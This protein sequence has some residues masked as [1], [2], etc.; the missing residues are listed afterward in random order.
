LGVRV[1]TSVFHSKFD[2]SK[3]L[4]QKRSLSRC[5]K[6]R[7]RMYTDTR[8]YAAPLSDTR[9]LACIALSIILLNHRATRTH[10]WPS[11]HPH[12][13]HNEESILG[14]SAKQQRIRPDHRVT[15]E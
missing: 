7:Q 8:R 1:V 12:R 10:T 6:P 9:V 3:G 15:T 11:L 5:P 4:G 2:A 13:S 14:R